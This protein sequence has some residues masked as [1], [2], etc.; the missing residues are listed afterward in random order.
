ME[1]KLSS[2]DAMSPSHSKMVKN[3]FTGAEMTELLPFKH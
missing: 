3:F 2:S 1:I